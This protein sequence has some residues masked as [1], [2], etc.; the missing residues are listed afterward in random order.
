MARIK[1]DPA[2]EYFSRWVRLRDMRC[3]RCGS[4]VRLNGKGL[5]VSHTNSHYFGRSSQNTRFEPNNC[6]TLCYPCHTNWSSTNKDEYRDFKIGQLG[7]RGYD[8]LLLASNTY[9]KK[10]YLAERIYWKAKLKEDFNV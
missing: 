6:D 4:R 5:P 8:L 2:D 10:D 9:R 7:Q 1:I 3:L